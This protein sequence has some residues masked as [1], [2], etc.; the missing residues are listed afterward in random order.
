M[1]ELFSPASGSHSDLW[2]LQGL[3]E[4]DAFTKIAAASSLEKQVACVHRQRYTKA[5][6]KNAV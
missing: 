2:R 4:V 5:Y 6:V 3:L 1:G